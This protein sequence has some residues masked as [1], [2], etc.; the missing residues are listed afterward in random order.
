[1]P[2]KRTPRC[3]AAL[4]HNRASAARIRA[5]LARP[6]VDLDRLAVTRPDARLR[7]RSAELVRPEEHRSTDEI[8]AEI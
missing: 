5:A 2:A 1:M 8:V 4:P 3:F 7:N 6:V